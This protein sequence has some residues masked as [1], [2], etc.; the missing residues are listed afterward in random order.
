[1]LDRGVHA[2]L[3]LPLS[4]HVSARCVISSPP[5]RSSHTDATHATRPG[6]HAR[7]TTAWSPRSARAG[8]A[9][10][11]ARTTPGSGAMS[12][13]RS[14]PS[15]L[16]ATPQESRASTARPRR[17]PRSTIRTS[18]RCTR[19]MRTGQPSHR[20][21]DTQGH[22]AFQRS[23][24][25]RP[26]LRPGL[27]RAGGLL[28]HAGLVLRHA[29]SGGCGTGYPLTRTRFRCRLGMP[30]SSGSGLPN[31]KP[32]RIAPCPGNRQKQRL[33]AGSERN[34]PSLTR[35]SL[36]RLLHGLERPS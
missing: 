23:H 3:G 18:S 7:R 13:S 31:S 36:R 33:K 15:R 14:S 11:G 34:E 32:T 27:H 30:K 6:R 24:R 35:H 10:S 12:R 8:W 17:W 21:G 22:R 29:A 26:R 19:S 16:R 1:M 5:T 20:R 9:W 4:V 28:Q 2:G 25:P